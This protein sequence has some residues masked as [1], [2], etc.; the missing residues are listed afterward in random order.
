MAQQ[1]GQYTALAQGPGLAPHTHI[2]WLTISFNS[3]SRAIQN[4]CLHIHGQ[5]HPWTYPPK[6]TPTHAHNQNQIY[7]LKPKIERRDNIET[8]W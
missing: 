4:L 2:K 3:S 1:L 8:S 6:H 5:I 7:S